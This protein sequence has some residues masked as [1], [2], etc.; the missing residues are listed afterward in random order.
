MD[1]S[2]VKSFSTCKFHAL[3]G[4][5]CRCQEVGSKSSTRSQKWQ[6]Q[7]LSILDL[8]RAAAICMGLELLADRLIGFIDSKKYF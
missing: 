8:G 1:A 5:V 4:P 6:G 2:Y 7:Q 3:C